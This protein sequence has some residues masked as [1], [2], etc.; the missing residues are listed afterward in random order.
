MSSLALSLTPGWGRGGGARR[1]RCGGAGLHKHTQQS[2]IWIGLQK[3]QPPT[4][5]SHW[6]PFGSSLSR[7]HLPSPL[8]LG[9]LHPSSV[10]ISY[11]LE[12]GL[13]SW[14]STCRFF[15]SAFVQVV[16]HLLPLSPPQHGSM[17]GRGDEGDK[18]RGPALTRPSSFPHR[19]GRPL[20]TQ[21][22]CIVCLAFLCLE[23]LS[24]KCPLPGQSLSPEEGGANSRQK[25]R[26]GRRP[27]LGL[28]FH[29]CRMGIETPPAS[30]GSR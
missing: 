15:P 19:Q 29:L 9:R 5:Y 27:S 24:E 1:S 22:L 30:P 8:R 3:S 17:V 28:S 23:L 12:R 25:E 14:A 21:P 20:G 6:G 2:Q 10:H 18:S 7:A 13:P 16:C 26:Q 11:S 4:S